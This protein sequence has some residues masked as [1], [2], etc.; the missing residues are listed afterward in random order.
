MVHELNGLGSS[1]FI[2]NRSTFIST[3][4]NK[5]DLDLRKYMFHNIDLKYRICRATR[6]WIYRTEWTLWLCFRALKWKD[7]QIKLR[8]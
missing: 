8:L 7:Y 4:F 2:S 1:Q 6:K 3:A 5:G